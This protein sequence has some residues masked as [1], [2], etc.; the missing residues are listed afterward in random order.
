MYAIIDIETTGGGIRWSRITEV[1]VYL[2]DGKQ[3]LESFSSLVNP[4]IPIPPFISQLTGITDDMVKDAPSFEEIAPEVERL[5]RNAV[6][7]AHNVQFD[8]NFIRQEFSL[9][10]QPFER[11]R[12]CTVRL[13]RHYLPGMNSYSLGKLCEDLDI[14]INARHRAAGD[15]EATV[16][17]LER[18]L[19][20][21]SLE[22]LKP[23][24]TSGSP[25]EQYNKRLKSTKLE[26]VPQS[27]GVLYFLDNED[28]LLYIEGTTNMRRRAIA[29]MR[30]RA[31]KQGKAV[32]QQMADLHFEETGS[33]L[34]AVLLANEHVLTQ[35]PSLNK[36][37]KAAAV[38]WKITATEGADSF[39]YLEVARC[40]EG[41][42]GPY[43]SRRLANEKLSE[44][45]KQ[46]YLCRRFSSLKREKCTSAAC[47]KACEGVELSDVYN[48]RAL[49]ALS[50]TAKPFT[51]Q[52]LLDRGRKASERVVV[53]EHESG[54]ISWGFVEGHLRAYTEE[55]LAA[56]ASKTFKSA[57]TAGILKK[58]LEKNKVQK[59]FSYGQKVV[60][61]GV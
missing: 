35:N 39:L 40:K 37:A 54:H 13:S 3:V 19:Q 16:K 60:A 24:I 21:G 44:L 14:P 8:Y 25:F 31:G 55:D 47:Q 12:M 56:A 48:K 28:K 52:L 29:F 58:Y 53:L 20:R 5:T 7:V 33:A 4:G 34:L 1:A 15:A 26:D 2:H 43:A 6:F 36:P 23:F 57:S 45:L 32:Q 11:D 38:R 17:V 42:S 50:S 49:E 10:G 9:L 41:E 61:A 59:I 27:A 51:A 46:F 22:M 18:V 30:N